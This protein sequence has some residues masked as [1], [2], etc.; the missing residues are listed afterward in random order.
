MDEVLSNLEIRLGLPSTKEKEDYINRK[1][2]EWDLSI[3]AMRRYD[4]ED[5]FTT[6]G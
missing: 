6:S 5:I 1:A 4:I 2:I 3:Q